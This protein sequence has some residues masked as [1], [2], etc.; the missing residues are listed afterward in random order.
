MRSF[1]SFRRCDSQ[2]FRLLL[3]LVVTIPQSDQMFVFLLAA[4]YINANR[5]GTR[6]EIRHDLANPRKFVGET[7]WGN[8]SPELSKGLVN[9]L[10]ALI[11][12]AVDPLGHQSLI[13]IMD[14]RPG[15]LVALLDARRNNSRQYLGSLG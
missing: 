5:P 3:R 6:L 7:L 15:F 12:R 2:G 13:L 1:V 4:V 8:G 9:P 11:G 14:A 10:V